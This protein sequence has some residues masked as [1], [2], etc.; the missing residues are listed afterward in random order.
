MLSCL[1]G[2]LC[3]LQ[4]LA[5]SALRRLAVTAV[6]VGLVLAP[7]PPAFALG[8]AE[9][10]AHAD[11]EAADPGHSH[12]DGETHGPFNSHTHGHDPADHSHQYGFL[13]G[14]GNAW[15][16]PPAQHWSSALSGRPD[17]VIDLGIERPPKHPMSP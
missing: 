1:F 10:P 14:E 4:I 2:I 13:S 5:R 9:G 11:L 6:A 3:Q 8:V 12:D 15:G 16:F 7:L 17:A